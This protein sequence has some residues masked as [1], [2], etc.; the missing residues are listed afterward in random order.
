MEEKKSFGPLIGIV[1]IIALVVVGGLYFLKNEVLNT[2]VAT[3]EENQITTEV[4][5]ISS[6]DDLDSL[7]NDLK[8]TPVVNY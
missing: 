7:E 1:I 5:P 2:P 4:A 6:G 3:P 8:V